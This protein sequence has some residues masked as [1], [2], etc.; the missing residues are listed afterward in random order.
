MHY[1]IAGLGNI[2]PEYDLTRHNIGFRIVEAIAQKQQT[3]FEVAPLAYTATFSYKGRQVTLIK[4]TTYMNHSGRSVRYWLQHLRVEPLRL[5]ILTD[6]LHLP[7]GQL[8]MRTKGSHGGHNGLRNLIEALGS[9]EYARLRF[10]IDRNFPQ[11][12]QA[13]YVLSPFSRE[14]AS[15]L[16]EL[17]EEATKKALSFCCQAKSL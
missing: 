3:P 13:D 11:G 9:S 16:P 15:Q 2:G 1:L 8:R 4:P 17:I 12:G 7:F 5:L 6:D 14:E 10:G